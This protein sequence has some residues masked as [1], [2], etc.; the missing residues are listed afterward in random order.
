MMINEKNSRRKAYG[1]PTVAINKHGTFLINKQA[2]NTLGVSEGS[3]LAIEKVKKDIFFRHDPENGFALK[4]DLN[5][6][7]RFTSI[8]AAK[9]VVGARVLDKTY[10]FEIEPETY[11][12]NR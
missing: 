8:M 3:R 2:A 1:K 9:S 6:M 7:L 11:K 12:I 10:R 5:G 4:I